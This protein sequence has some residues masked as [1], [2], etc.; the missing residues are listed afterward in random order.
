MADSKPTDGGKQAGENETS[1]LQNIPIRRGPLPL[2]IPIIQHLNS[3]RVILASAS[4]RRK[5]LLQ[6]IGLKNLEILPSTKPEDV[7]KGAYG[8]YEYVE[9]TARK[10]CLDVYSIA[11]ENSMKSIPDPSLVI[12]ADTIIVTR[13]GRI[14]EKPRN[15]ADHIRML[16]H[17]RD[18]RVHKV[19]TSIS[20]IAPREDARAPGYEL[21][22][23][24]E[25]TKVYFWEEEDGLPDDVIEAYVKT[26]EGADKAG[27]YAIQGMGGMLLAE[28]IDGS[29]DNV[30][31]LPVRRT[32]SMA[33]KAIFQQE[34]DIYEEGG[35]EEED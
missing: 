3:K 28:K 9:E 34:E 5:A 35:E 23:H 19:L 30:V 16:K 27:G 33:E 14:L 8:P 15:E 22:T 20:V 4:P 26:R 21:V 25:E 18:T 1:V 24:T 29:V 17:L 10:K 7:D 11:L 13:D 2:E 32:L 12:A 31:G 6:Q